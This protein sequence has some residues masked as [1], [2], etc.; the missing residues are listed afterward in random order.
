MPESPVVVIGAS[1]GGVEALLEIIPRLPAT[2]H[3]SLIVV[4]H[5]PAQAESMLRSILARHSRLPVQEVADKDELLPGRIYLAPPN[6]H[7]LLER[8]QTFSLCLSAPVHYCRPAIDVC[9]TAVADAC[10]ERVIGVILT[11]ANN[12][13]AEGIRRIKARGGETLAQDPATAQAP[14]MPA[15]AIQTG[16]IDHV[17]SLAELADYL[18]RKLTLQ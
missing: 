12:D 6:Y 15:S 7:L 9:M 4:L 13:G 3:A 2:S 18:V 1:A 11:G 5:Q 16:C 17:F 14:T 8:D 10:C